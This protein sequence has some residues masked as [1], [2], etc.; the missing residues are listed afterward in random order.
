MTTLRLVEALG[1]DIAKANLHCLVAVAFANPDLR[2]NTRPD[3][4]H[5]DWDDRTRLIK[6]L[7]H[8]DLST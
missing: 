2:D 7:G 4:Q 8:A 1:L 3:F 6:N 5:S